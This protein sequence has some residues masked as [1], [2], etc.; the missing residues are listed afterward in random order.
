MT[1]CLSREKTEKK[2]NYGSIQDGKAI[3]VT[4]ESDIMSFIGNSS[5]GLT[6]FSDL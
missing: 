5:V 1:A 6:P 3:S 2:I 4:F